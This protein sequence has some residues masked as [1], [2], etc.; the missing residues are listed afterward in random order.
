[1]ATLYDAPVDELLDELADRLRDDL[2]EPDWQAFAKSGEGRELAPQQDD[3]WFRRGASVL[4]KVAVDGPVGVERLTTE[5]G[6]AKQGSN[7]YRVAPRRRSD[8]SGSVIRTLLQQLEEAGYVQDT[9][10]EGR[11]VTAEG[12]SLL[13]ETAGDVIEQLDRPELQRY[14]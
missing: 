5:Y 11:R 9:N 12:R 6:N 13:D 4:R 3:F 7:R 14:A 8:G 10:G 1:M 2:E